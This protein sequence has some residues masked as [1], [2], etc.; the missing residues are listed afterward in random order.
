MVRLPTLKN[1]N[2]Y[3]DLIKMYT[4]YQKGEAATEQESLALSTFEDMM[5]S[6]YDKNRENGGRLSDDRKEK[7]ISFYSR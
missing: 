1:Q 4:I 6:I 5:F 3:E 7:Y 2:T